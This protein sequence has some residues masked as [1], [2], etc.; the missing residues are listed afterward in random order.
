MGATYPPTWMVWPML[1]AGEPQVLAPNMVFFLHV[2]LLNSDTGFEHVARRKPQSSPK[3]AASRSATP[4]AIC[5][6]PSTVSPEDEC[7]V[8]DGRSVSVAKAWVG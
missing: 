2:I 6:L 1:Y 3:P 7:R 8:T 5:W 4:R